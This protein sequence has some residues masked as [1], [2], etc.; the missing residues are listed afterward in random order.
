MSTVDG[1][2]SLGTVALVLSLLP[3]AALAPGFLGVELTDEVRFGWSM[4]NAACV[5]AG[6][7]LSIICVRGSSSRNVAGM[8]A[9]IVS[10]LFLLLMLG[11]VGFGIV[12]T[13]VL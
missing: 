7:A 3:L 13:Y 9:M 1:K 4:I 6:L 12:N 2:K 10:S 5:I 11:I 8:V